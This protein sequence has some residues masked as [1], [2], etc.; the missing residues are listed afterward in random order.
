MS[1]GHPGESEETVR[2]IER[3]L[4][5]VRPADFDVTVIT[6]YPGSPYYDRSAVNGGHWTYEIDGDVLHSLEVDYET[7]SN[8]Y[9]GTPGEYT[10]YVW[11]DYLGRDDIVRLRD[12]V[13]YS[14]RTGLGLSGPRVQHEHSMGSA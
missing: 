6:P 2:A 14:A 7:T 1:I 9:K 5:E 10:S 3:W 13:E 4:F 12:E 11:T 8:F